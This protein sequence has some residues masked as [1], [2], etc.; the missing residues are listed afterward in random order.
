MR[1]IVELVPKA[2]DGSSQGAQDSPADARTLSE[3]PPEDP[4]A[5]V[6]G[7]SLRRHVHAALF[8]GAAPADVDPT[9][10]PTQVG[11]F[12]ITK[13]LGHGGM[14]EVLAGFDDELERP[15]A[16]K[17]LHAEIGQEHGERLRREAKA[18]AQLS[19]PN[20]VQV[21]EVGSWQDQLFIAMELVEGRT[22]KAWLAE[23]PHPLDDILPMFVSAGAG[24]AA[25]HDRE[26]IH[27]DFKPD[28]VVVGDDGRPRILDFG[29]ARQGSGESAP[30]LEHDVR[31]S[32]LALLDT[33]MPSG[34]GRLGDSLTQTGT[35]LGTPAYMPPEQ[36]RGEATH[37][38]SDQFSF[39]VALWE[40]TYGERPFAGKNVRELAVA[41]CNGDIHRPDKSRGSAR[42]RRAITRGLA[43]QPDERWPGMQ[44]LLAELEAI[45]NAPMRRRRAAVAI[46]SLSV[47]AAA[48]TWSLVRPGADAVA[49]AAVDERCR[50]ASERFS[51][52]WDAKT[53]ERLSAKYKSSTLAAQQWWSTEESLLD[54]W[55]A[56]WS[57]ISTATCDSDERERAPLLFE[58]RQTCLDQRWN[59]IKIRVSTMEQ[60]DPASRA[61]AAS[62]DYLPFY[63]PRECENDK[64]VGAT[65][66]YPADPAQRREVLDAYLQL[67]L[68]E[69]RAQAASF[70]DPNLASGD[71][72]EE[73]GIVKE[74]VIATGFAPIVAEQAA[75]EGNGT[76]VGGHRETNGFARIEEA[77]RLAQDA[78]V[79]LIYVLAEL[80]RLENQ[81]RR[82][83]PRLTQPGVLADLERWEAALQRVGAPATGMIELSDLRA[84]HYGSV[85]NAAAASTEIEASI[86]LARAAY[87]TET[88][89]MIRVLGDAALAASR[90]G[91]G[92]EAQRHRGE[93]SEIIGRIYGPNS[94]HLLALLLPQTEEA[95]RE[96]RLDDA[97]S[98]AGRA[99]AVAVAHH[100]DAGTA[101]L[102]AKLALGSVQFARGD[103][104]AVQAM[105]D[106]AWGTTGLDRVFLS[107][108]VELQAA[109][110]AARGAT[111][112]TVAERLS[113][114]QI[115]STFSNTMVALTIPLLDGR[116][117]AKALSDVDAA[118][119]GVDLPVLRA[120][121]ALVRAQLLER[122]GQYLASAEAYAEAQS[123]GSYG[124]FVNGLLYNAAAGGVRALRKAEDPSAD[125]LTVKVRK[126]LT[127]AM[128]SHPL[129][130]EL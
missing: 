10:M 91:L 49:T 118:I 45:R 36:L 5:A 115:D 27:R 69:A 19:H 44:A 78:R 4:R 35:I 18:L 47:A 39:C 70:G 77:S 51:G 14:G 121:G 60:L 125:A 99:L 59:E 94:F 24:L 48:A 89:F 2:D 84:Q 68:T 103:D 129:L 127:D 20:V 37:A 28:N 82:G 22:L 3:T 13:R 75:R 83:N 61:S 117:V 67:R 114:T 81:D 101:V 15:V 7:S 53:R 30:T 58:Q 119:Q 96:H 43:V 93:S 110:A 21:Y 104:A 130:A 73:F 62:G 128:P 86:A 16:V 54:T 122:D 112:P 74:R 106:A 123:C 109:L 46:G 88:P 41:V 79:E 116:P 65:V 76:L 8:G 40:A 71:L 12:R 85:G 6:V 38:G 92:D 26:L 25:A 1:G 120:M 32:D 113:T 64:L 72:M 90:A 23:G 50:P 29:L 66:A 9:G 107:M 55:V 80:W 57:R 108:A 17:L 63:L 102:G 87:G 34:S 31:P 100:G 98:F 11:R 42:L 124:G 52:I 126:S 33:V 56:D 105:L 97:F 95:L 111:D